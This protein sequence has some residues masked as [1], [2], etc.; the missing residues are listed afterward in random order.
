MRSCALPLACLILAGLALGACTSSSP[1]KSR[2]QLVSNS[3]NCGERRFEIYFQNDQASLT[4]SALTALQLTAE[5]LKACQITKVQVTGLADARG[6]VTDANQSLSERRAKA[7]AEALQ[8]I[9]LPA[10]AFEVQAAGA[11]G[12]RTDGIND[13]LRRRTEVV[14]SST[15]PR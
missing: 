15:V 10:P 1:Y 9:G 7:V 13:P 4:P 2:D 6:G 14:I 5:Q 3:L 11:S 8:T 12:A